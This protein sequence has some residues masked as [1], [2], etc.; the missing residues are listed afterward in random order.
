MNNTFCSKCNQVQSSCVCTNQSLLSCDRISYCINQELYNIRVNNSSAIPNFCSAVV[1]CV[2]AQFLNVLSGNPTTFQYY[3]DSILKVLKNL[4]NFD[5]NSTK[6]LTSSGNDLIWAAGGAGSI[7]LQ[8]GVGIVLNG[9]NTSI[10]PYII[11]STI[12]Q[13]TDENAQDAIGNI[14]SSEF[15]YNDSLPKISINTID[16]TKIV[17]APAFG[18]VTSVSLALPNIFNVTG[19]PVISSGTLT[20]TF[21]NQT[22]NRVFAGPTSGGPGVPTFRALVAADIPSLGSY[23]TSVPLNILLPAVATN[24]INSGNFQQEWQWN[25]LSSGTGLKISSNTTVASGGFSHKLFSVELSGNNV[26]ASQTTYGIS[27]SNSHGGSLGTN[28]GI[29]G[30]ASNGNSSVG[31]RG[32]ATSATSSGIGGAFYATTSATANI[33][34]YGFASGPQSNAGYFVSTSGNGGVIVVRQET[35]TLYSSITYDTAALATSWGAG[36]YLL[37]G[38][39]IFNTS[40]VFGA[41]N[42]L[43]LFDTGKVKIAD[44]YTLPNTDGGPNQVLQTD[45]F[46]NVNWATVVAGGGGGG[47]TSINIISPLAGITASGGP[48]TSSGS[49]TLALADD[50]AALEALSST[51]IARRT[52]LNTWALGGTVTIAE[53]G[54][55][56]TTLG[57]SNQLLRVNGGGTA[58]EYFTPSFLT[59]NQTITLTGDVTGSGTTSIAT[60]ISNNVVTY[61]KIQTVMQ[62]RLLGRFTASTGNVQEISL[63]SGLTLDSTTGVL[64]SISGGSGTVTS[65]SSGNLAPLFTTN[66]ATATT[67]PALTFSLTTAAANTY[68]GNATGSTAA[69]SYTSAGALT[70]TDDTNVTLTLGGNPAT[71]LLRAASLTLG[72]TGQ[73]SLARGGT[74]ANLVDPNADRIMFWD[75]S[76]NQV[77]WLSMG[78]NIS[79][80]GTTLNVT[81]TG[82]SAVIAFNATTDWGSPSGGY[83]SYAFTHSLASTDVIA[84]VWDETGT[85]VQVF[86]EIVERTSTNIVT[87]KVTASPD[88]RFAGRLVIKS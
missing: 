45:G 5:I 23:L 13:Y 66:V 44:S 28:Y 87:I 76:A 67:T 8:A 37:D 33:G 84:F 15:N 65:F 43:Q 39:F 30:S 41:L 16:W 48:I 17:N 83:Y 52:A 82:G 3:S 59:G 34:V 73:L 7:F 4:L 77:T 70:K 21:V 85:P 1:K 6:V 2:D 31:V 22:A 72:W 18:T 36:V 57:T 81:G 69:P 74:G 79:I 54:T 78:T 51:G 24:V 20:G 68:L 47:V 27:G 71:S 10:D 26:N 61:A 38:S 32:E 46:G 14:L 40:P 80:T 64:D 11:S 63:G 25:T 29:I 12:T 75:D 62:A 86:P 53:G 58:L 88:N 35:P 19:S 50:L 42:V 49:I 56:L 55:N 60:L 9:S